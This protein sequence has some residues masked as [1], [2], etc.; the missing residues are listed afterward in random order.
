MLS[1]SAAT[2]AE[3]NFVVG[4]FVSDFFGAK[5]AVLRH[6]AIKLHGE[7]W[8]PIDRR[9]EPRPLPADHVGAGD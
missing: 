6:Q 9:R 4:A 1:R 2:A 8:Q 3:V 5:L 7:D